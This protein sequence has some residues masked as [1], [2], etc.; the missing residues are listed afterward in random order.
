MSGPEVLMAI[1]IAAF[2]IGNLLAMFALRVQRRAMDLRMECKEIQAQVEALEKLAA[3]KEREECAA[4]ADRLCEEIF[5]DCDDA[6]EVG[7]A[8]RFRR[9]GTCRKN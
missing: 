4:L 6:A 8:I 2:M 5:G 3:I 9:E 1:S 7:K